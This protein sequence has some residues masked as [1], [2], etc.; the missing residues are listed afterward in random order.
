MDSILKPA[1]L[2]LFPSDWPSKKENEHG[3]KQA[4]L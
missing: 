3:T 4:N 2:D 1:E